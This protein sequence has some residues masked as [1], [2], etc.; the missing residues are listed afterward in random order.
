[1]LYEIIMASQTNILTGITFSLFCRV[2]KMPM[3][4]LKVIF[5]KLASFSLDFFVLFTF[6]VASLFFK[7]KND[8]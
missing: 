7:K 1:M 3:F 5:K 2:K 8:T 4:M 6:L